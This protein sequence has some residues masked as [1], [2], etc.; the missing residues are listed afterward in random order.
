MAQDL[1]LKTVKKNWARG[2]RLR[3]LMDARLSVGKPKVAFTPTQEETDRLFDIATLKL[4][5]QS[6]DKDAQERWKVLR[7]QV[8]SLKKKAKSGDPKSQ[9]ALQLLSDSRI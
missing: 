3:P 6:G 9:R 2:T 5:A 4:S 7:V 1:V 8:E